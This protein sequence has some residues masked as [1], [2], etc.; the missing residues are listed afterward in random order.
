[1]LNI[2]ESAA[3]AEALRSRMNGAVLGR[4]DPEF[5]A[6]RRLFN[7]AI[8]TQ[9]AVMAQC[10]NPEEICTAMM[11][12]RENGLD[13]SVRGG[14]H[15][16]AGASLVEDGLVIDL[17]A[18]N[19][20]SVD[21]VART[22]TAGGG[23]VW[24]DVDRAT[25]QYRLATTGGRVSST[26]VA[27]LALGGGSGWLE[28]KFGLA[29]DNLLSVDLV[30]ADG[31]EITASEQENPEL[32]WALHGGGGNF[33]VATRLTFRLHELPEFSAALMIWEN[34]R[35]PEALRA[36]RDLMAQAP[37]EIGG[38]GISLTA[39]PEAFVP[40]WM[41]GTPAFAVLVTCIGPE[42][43]LRGRIAPLLDLAPAGSTT[44]DIP[45]ADLQCMLDD[46]PGYRNYWS[47][48][49]LHDL[50][51]AA[52]DAFCAR[53]E[54]MIVPS[55]SQSLV[56]PWGG[57]VARGEGKWPMVN[58]SAP[59]VVHPLGMWSDPAQ[60]ER[61]VRWARGI[62]ETMRPFTT[63]G[64]YL[65]FIGDEGR[66][67]IV[68]GFGEEN[69]RRLTRIKAQFDPDNMFHRWHNVL[70]ARPAAVVG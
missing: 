8:E 18:M 35:S 27:G 28:R 1:M 7:S 69:Y 55:P 14:G 48:E 3:I 11:F 50:P 23:A 47:G 52:V 70:P 33:G 37:D 42:S 51:D 9:P 16:V 36:F 15:S 6:A 32:F 40:E 61:A 45:Y 66:E 57:E 46:P 21:P 30:I 34:A 58:R 12:A 25:Q 29:C 62:R 26:G 64:V 4:A 39:P 56:V 10:A 68:A 20:V 53:A 19:E 54:D 67:R 49:Y 43:E 24:G 17:R 2:S 44:M 65:N 60:D 38:A 41:V 59:W 22:V 31:S 63:G 5:A 13:L